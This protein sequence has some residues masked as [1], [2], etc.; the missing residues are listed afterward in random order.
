[1]DRRASPRALEKASNDKGSE[2]A[3]IADSRAA[4]D[5][6]DRETKISKEKAINDKGSERARRA[7]PR[8]SGREASYN[9]SANTEGIKKLKISKE[10]MC[11]TR[12]QHALEAASLLKV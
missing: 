7:T 1:M 2:R 3:V 4:E 9:E 11:N 12:V 10:K 6:D 5:K 8:G